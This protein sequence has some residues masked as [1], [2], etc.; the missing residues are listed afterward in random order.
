MRAKHAVSA[1]VLTL[2]PLACLNDAPSG[3]GTPTVRL[4]LVAQVE[5][6][7]T[8]RTIQ[9]RVFYRRMS[10]DE[11]RLSATPAQLRVPVGSTRT[12]A[13]VVSIGA[14]LEDPKREEANRLGCRFSVEL[15]LL[16][17]DGTVISRDTKDTAAPVLPGE[18]VRF[19]HFSLAGIRSRTAA[20]SHSDHSPR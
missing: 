6:E 11:V 5:G 8:D 20:R 1:M 2:V 9:I 4:S 7:A 13:V 12:E 19:P 14:C 10:Q 15:Q 3:L 17:P 16:A 18:T